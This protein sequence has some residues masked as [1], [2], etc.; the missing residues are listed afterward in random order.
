MPIPLTPIGFFF[1]TFLPGS[2]GGDLAKLYYATRENEGH[3][4]E[5]ATVC[6]STT[7][8]ACSP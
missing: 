7:S 8:S 3:R 5:V 6:C 2:A 1:S 4:A